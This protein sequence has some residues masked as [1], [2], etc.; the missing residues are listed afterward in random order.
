MSQVDFCASF[1]ALTGQTLGADDAPD[2]FNVLPALL[3][4]SKTG[5]DHVIEHANKL[6]IREGK[7]KFIPGGPPSSGGRPARQ[8][9]AGSAGVP[10]A[11]SG[12]G[13]TAPAG[14]APNSC[15]AAVTR[16]STWPP[17]RR[18]TENV[19]AKHPDVVERLAKKL[20]QVRTQDRSRP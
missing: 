15:P 6:A 20:E 18:E 7:W 12:R 1:A 19:A 2:S 17:T 13:E 3:G 5:R 8:E 16:S 9:Q 14:S 4:E 10:P 11:K